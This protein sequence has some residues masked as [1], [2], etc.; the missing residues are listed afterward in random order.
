[1]TGVRRPAVAGRFYALDAIV[2]LGAGRLAESVDR[3]GISMCG[4]GPVMAMMVAMRELNATGAKV[5]CY[6]TSGDSSGDTAR[7]VGYSTVAVEV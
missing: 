2:S 1:M 7:V 3:H 5:L 4:L 6:G